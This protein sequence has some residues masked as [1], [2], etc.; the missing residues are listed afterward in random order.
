VTSVPR[1]EAIIAA[2]SSG[3]KSGALALPLK[4]GLARQ[5]SFGVA[6]EAGGHFHH[7]ADAATEQRQDFPGHLVGRE[8]AVAGRPGD[9]G[10]EDGPAQHGGVRFIGA[11]EIL[12]ALGLILPLVTGI[13]PWLTV[14]AAAGLVIIQVAAVIFH[15]QRGE[16]KV[17]PM[18]LVLLILALAVVYGRAV[19][20]QA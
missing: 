20:V 1:L 17:V 6:S 8:L 14:V 19:I 15:L 13:L 2:R 3:S 16:A 5:Q 9:A 11:A 7:A 4:N 12:G 18:N 10:S